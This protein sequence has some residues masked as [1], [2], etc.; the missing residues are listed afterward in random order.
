MSDSPKSSTSAF[1][2]KIHNLDSLQRSKAFC[3]KP[4]V[5]LFVSHFGTVVPCCLT[6]WEK[7]QALGD[8]N[9]ESID[10]IWNGRKM[11]DFRIKMLNDEQDSRC[12]QCYEN[13]NVGLR[14]TRNITNLLYSDKLHWA[15]N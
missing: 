8:I 7:E 12:K 10:E 6:P 3:I 2:R 11:G 9:E 4:W 15:L 14:S 1:E 5:H 13:E